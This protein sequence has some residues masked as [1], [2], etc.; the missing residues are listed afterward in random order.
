MVSSCICARR[1]CV[2]PG[3][4]RRLLGHRVF[5]NPLYLVIEVSDSNDHRRT[6]GSADRPCHDSCFSF[7]LPMHVDIKRI[8]ASN[9][10]TRTPRRRFR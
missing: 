1:S 6:I 2:G 4:C 5:R 3:R 10:P 8:H 7:L 9:V